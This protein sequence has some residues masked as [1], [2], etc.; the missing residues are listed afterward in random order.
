MRAQQEPK[1]K[2]LR[3]DSPVLAGLV[4]LNQHLRLAEQAQL[5]KYVVDR[6][7]NA[8]FSD[9]CALNSS[10]HDIA[11]TLKAML[12]QNPHLDQKA[13]RERIFHVLNDFYQ[14]INA[15]WILKQ[16]PERL[17]TA[18]R[19]LHYSRGWNKALN[20]T[21]DDAGY[22]GW[23]PLHF[24]AAC[25]PEGNIKSWDD[26]HQT[27]SK[28]LSYVFATLKIKQITS[29]NQINLAATKT[30]KQHGAISSN[31]L[32]FLTLYASDQAIF[33]Y[34]Q[35]LTDEIFSAALTQKISTQRFCMHP[36]V[37]HSVLAK[38]SSWLIEHLLGRCQGMVLYDC[39]KDQLQAIRAIIAANLQCQDADFHQRICDQVHGVVVFGAW[40][41][42]LSQLP[43]K[44]GY[45]DCEKK[46]QDAVDIVGQLKQANS[47]AELIELARRANHPENVPVF[48]EPLKNLLGA[49]NTYL[50]L[51]GE[52]LQL[53]QASF[54]Y[55]YAKFLPILEQ[56]FTTHALCPQ[57]DY[58]LQASIFR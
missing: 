42:C 45:G 36:T 56:F 40:Y 48:N 1:S 30:A 21:C 10:R 51:R 44:S 57:A 41:H 23:T 19:S 31:V 46:L 5:V 35:K 7:P 22:E 24:I 2:R 55:A 11:K 37:L 50:H 25:V 52:V 58:Q 18:I 54:A 33:E 49:Q 32:G 12:K 34:T 38:R 9:I 39:C 29:T 28:L 3:Q 47:E 16:A 53:T 13:Q 15:C 8:L 17:N 27:T 26:S 14:L 6:S 20:Y 4:G 43:T